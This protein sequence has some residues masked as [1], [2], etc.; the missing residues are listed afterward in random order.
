MHISIIHRRSASVH[1]NNSCMTKVGA[2]EVRYCYCPPASPASLSFP[3]Y[4]SVS[5]VP[6][7]THLPRSEYLHFPSASVGRENFPS[8]R[9]LGCVRRPRARGSCSK[10]SNISVACLRS[11]RDAYPL[12]R[13]SEHAD[14][15]ARLALNTS[16]HVSV[17]ETHLSPYKFL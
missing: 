17:D 7:K 4:Q 1:Q 8:E 11:I 16:K 13:R 5:V 3:P 2:E 10:R 9:A 12:H 15:T 14:F 6:H